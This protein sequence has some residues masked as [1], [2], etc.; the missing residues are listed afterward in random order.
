MKKDIYVLCGGKSVEHDV[1]LISAAG[2]IN[3]LNREK[4]RV[5]HI[6]IN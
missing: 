1:S 6:Y 5:K 4:Y 2:I 3:S